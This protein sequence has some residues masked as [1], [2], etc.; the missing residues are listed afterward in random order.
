[1]E[2]GEETS[3]VGAAAR[4]PSGA[5]AGGREGGRE[6]N[7]LPEH[8]G[9]RH[10]PRS[11]CSGQES[12]QCSDMLVGSNLC[13]PS[14]LSRKR[15]F[16]NGIL[17]SA[18]LPGASQGARGLGN[19]QIWKG[20][21][22]SHR[23]NESGSSG[24]S[25]LWSHF[26]TSDAFLFQRIPKLAG[27]AAPRVRGGLAGPG[28]RHLLSLK[29]RLPCPGGSWGGLSH[30]LGRGQWPL[31]LWWQEGGQSFHHRPAP[32]QVG[33]RD[34]DV[35]TSPGAMGRAAGPPRR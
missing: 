8:Q 7:L 33:S 4:S 11:G 32:P 25:G 29:L 30:F 1:M 5:D 18:L 26:W 34:S 27:D 17:P 10:H 12:P 21:Q 9:P 35:P 22:G 6:G 13:Y 31:R 15:R 28:V 2:D 24:P 14:V 19:G 16:P 23:P 20:C 3:G